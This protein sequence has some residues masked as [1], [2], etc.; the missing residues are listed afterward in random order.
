VTIEP[1]GGGDGHW[2]VKEVPESMEA[3]GGG[4]KQPV[5]TDEE[6]ARGS[7]LCPRDSSRAGRELGV[8]SDSGA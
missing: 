8:G 1:F 4:G 6:E 7:R 3:Q 5:T 2:A